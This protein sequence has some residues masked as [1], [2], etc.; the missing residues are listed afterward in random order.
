[1]PLTR[2]QLRRLARQ[3]R[4][5]HA[6][7]LLAL[8]ATAGL[9]A[10]AQMGARLL[11]IAPAALLYAALTVAWLRRYLDLLGRDCPRCGDLFFFS[12]ERLLYSL[13]YLSP[14][15]AHCR[16]PL[17]GGAASPPPEP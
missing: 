14:H 17:A 13:P 3:R 4:S 7:G 11:A 8:A 6:E 12:H 9:V 1:V 5:L 10:A 15:C 16:E 2:A